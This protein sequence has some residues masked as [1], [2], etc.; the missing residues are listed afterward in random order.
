MTIMGKIVNRYGFMKIPVHN[1]LKQTGL[2]ENFHYKGSVDLIQV[3]L[4]DDIEIEVKLT[5]AASRIIVT[6]TLKTSITLTCSRC[7]EQFNLPL[8]ILLQEEFLPATAA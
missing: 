6:G 7:L 2:S 8:T 1:I 5:N 4:A 3:D